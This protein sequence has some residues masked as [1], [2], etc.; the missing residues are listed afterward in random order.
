MPISKFCSPSV[1]FYCSNRIFIQGQKAQCTTI[2]TN[3]KETP[4]LQKVLK[5]AWKLGPADHASKLGDNACN[6][7]E[8][9]KA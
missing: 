2:V 1:I 6:V 5:L 3:D 8:A 4:R 7:C 9:M